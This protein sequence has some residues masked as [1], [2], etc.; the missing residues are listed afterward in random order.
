MVD[1]HVAPPTNSLFDVK[2]ENWPLYL[3]CHLELFLS[4]F[5][6]AP[7]LY[8]RHIKN[9][10]SWYLQAIKSSPNIVGTPHNCSVSYLV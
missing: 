3:W 9:M 1:Q 4:F 8:L 10:I 2:S 7:Q 5:Y 6:L